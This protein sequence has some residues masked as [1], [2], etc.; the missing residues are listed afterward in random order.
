MRAVVTRSGGLVVA[1]VDDPVP[2]PGQ[3]VVRSLSAGICGSDLHAL[4]DFPHFAELMAR[5]GA[6]PLDPGADTVFGHEFCAEVV[7]YGPDTAGHRPGRWRGCAPSRWCSV[8]QASSR[9][10]T[11]TPSPG[12]WPSTWCSR[13]CSSYRS[14]TRSPP[15]WPP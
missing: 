15:T 11:P 9:S 2:G 5:V 1:D 13:S 6:P 4:A 10:A 12:P 14:R 8:R 7:E 3:V